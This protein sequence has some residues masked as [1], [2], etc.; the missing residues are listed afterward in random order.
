MKKKICET[1]SIHFFE[2]FD[3]SPTNG[4]PMKN[5]DLCMNPS[6]TNVHGSDLPANQMFNLCKKKRR[7]NSGDKIPAS[8][9]PRKKKKNSYFLLYG[10]FNRDPYNGLL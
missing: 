1:T 2:F 5:D 9:E 7:C 10:L 3:P 8:I 6:D 4:V